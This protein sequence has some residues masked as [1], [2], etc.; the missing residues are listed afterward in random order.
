MN[1]NIN[2]GSQSGVKKDMT[3]E[4]LNEQEMP[5]GKIQVQTVGASQSIAQTEDTN[6]LLKDGMLVRES[7]ND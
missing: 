1:D 4:I 3:F 6:S 7:F 5:V 2:I